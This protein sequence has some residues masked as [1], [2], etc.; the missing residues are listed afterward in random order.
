M[1]LIVDLCSL[2]T[3]FVGVD[4]RGHFYSNV[5]AMRFFKIGSK[6]FKF[7]MELWLGESKCGTKQFFMNFWDKTINIPI[8]RPKLFG[9]SFAESPQVHL[10]LF[11]PKLFREVEWIQSASSDF[12]SV[13]ITESAQFIA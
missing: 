8:G 12:L 10:F 4:P 7:S 1:Y 2:D 6:T 5:C 9:N 3:T 13:I 11:A